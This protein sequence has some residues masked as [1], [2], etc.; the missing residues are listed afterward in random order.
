MNWVGGSRNRF[1]A[2]NDAK[3]QR[4]FFEKRKM[5]HKLKNL[6]LAV[7]DSPQGT[8]SGGMDLV[9]LFIV[10][11]IAAKKEIKDPPK[12]AVFGSSKGGSKHKRNEPLVLPMS[13][14]SPSQLSLV[15]G[16]PQWSDQ[17]QRK[18]K[19][20]I[21]RG[22]KCGQLSPVLE[23]AF[24]DNS[25]SDYLPP[26]TGP[27]SPFSSTSSASVQGI[28]PLQLNLQQRSQTQLPRPCSLPL[29]DSAVLGHA[30]PF[31]QPRDM[32]DCIPWSCAPNPPLFQLE[33]PTA[34][35]VLF[36]SPERRNTEAWDQAG[37]EVT[38]SL[39]QLEDKEPVLDYTL[40][41][42]ESQRQFEGEVFRGFS[43]EEC[44][45]EASHFGRG[46]SKIYLKEETAAASS[47][48]QTVP[49]SQCMEVEGRHH[50][51]LSNC[52]DGNSF[53]AC[54]E[55]GDGPANG[56]EYSAGCSCSG[57][58]LSSDSGDDEE[59]RQPPGLQAAASS[60]M[61]RVFCADGLDSCAASQ[62][63][64]KQR[65]SR[66]ATPLLNPGTGFRDQEVTGNAVFQVKG[67]GSNAPPALA[68]SQSSEACTC[69][70]TSAETREAG[71]Q[72]AG[73]LAA[74]TR[75]TWTQCGGAEAGRLDA[76][77]PPVDV[78]VQPPATGRQTDTAAEPRAHTPPSHKW[79]SGEKHTP[80]T[81]KPSNPTIGAGSSFVN[82]SA[83]GRA[84]PQRPRN[85][86]LE[87]LSGTDGG[88]KDE[89]EDRGRQE[90]GRLMK[91]LSD[92]A[93][94][95]VTSGTAA[96]RLSE[97]AETLQEI[98]DILLLLKRRK[99]VTQ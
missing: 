30:E 53:A 48:A 23:S 40:H 34:A 12:V 17:G 63:S 24:S 85:P 64:A 5:Q 36:R 79:R 44:D 72:T 3:K 20:V 14:C 83:D 94:E 92:E 78:S 33:T 50:T 55:H 16:E 9:T 15:E 47:T 73:N 76:R 49:D 98:A 45:E 19:H 90:N 96:H 10:N 61:D 51:H 97:E 70:K 37:R 87:A 43:T 80:W 46:T 66:P 32:T 69:K 99:E 28:F 21:P 89:A 77:L 35:Q 39:G 59:C 38:F 25:A 11:Q 2:K 81:R 18:R 71:T 93:M 86:F 68:Q 88:G 60:H 84:D 54:L 29:W 67:R 41:R 6:G 4:E 57:G 91:G 82:K 31:S 56:S 74:E 65:L 1:A 8:S 75:D 62:G 26:M 95:E 22:F 52:A 42:E 27:L 7:P 13:P 58:Y